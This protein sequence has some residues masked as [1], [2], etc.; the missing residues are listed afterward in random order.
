MTRF[1]RQSTSIYPADRK[2]QRTC[3][4]LLHLTAIY[5][6]YTYTDT[7]VT[8]VILFLDHICRAFSLTLTTANQL[9]S[10][11]QVSAVEVIS[12][13]TPWRILQ[14]VKESGQ[15]K[16]KFQIPGRISDAVC[17]PAILHFDFDHFWH[18]SAVLADIKSRPIPG[19][20]WFSI[21]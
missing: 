7:Y 1:L 19:L 17:H 3:S 4:D 10:A 6:T 13:L 2:D 15:T 8:C 5:N 18:F 14:S 11:V 16:W 9:P 12:G 21:I 20:D